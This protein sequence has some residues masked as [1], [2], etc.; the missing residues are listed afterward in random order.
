MSLEP[1]RR[2]NYVCIYALCSRD[3]SCISI[4]IRVLCSGV[5]TLGPS[6]SITSAYPACVE[7]PP[8]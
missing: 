7:Q 8:G 5:S 1:F 4:C 6:T 2:V 3:T